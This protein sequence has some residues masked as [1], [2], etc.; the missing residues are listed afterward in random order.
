VKR[1][2][3]ALAL[4]LLLAPSACSSDDSSGGASGSAWATGGVSAEDAKA[5]YEQ[6]VTPVNC[7]NNE[8]QKVNAAI[9]NPDGSIEA[10]QWAQL[11]PPLQSL[12]D[13]SRDFAVAVGNAN[14]PSAISATD[15]EK[16]A[17][18][19]TAYSVILGQAASAKDANEF[20]SIVTSEG[21]RSALDGAAAAA[22]SVR[23]QLGLAPASESDDSQGCP[24][25]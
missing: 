3:A 25:G 14:W 12:A 22:D 1:I 10:D 23:Q 8:L 19:A 9:T 24:A 13:A 17:T 2:A 15:I 18:T 20:A 4:V 21:F 7:A 6:L 5:Q 16:L 11:Q